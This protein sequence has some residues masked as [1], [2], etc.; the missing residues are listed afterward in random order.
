M[1]QHHLRRSLAGFARLDVFFV[2]RRRRRARG[3][4]PEPAAARNKLHRGD[5]TLR[6]SSDGLA[7]LPAHAA[8]HRGAEI[9]DGHRLVILHRRLLGEVLHVLLERLEFLLRERFADERVLRASRRRA[10]ARTRVAVFRTHLR[11]AVL[12]VPR[13]RGLALSPDAFSGLEALVV[14][15]DLLF[16]LEERRCL[17]PPPRAHLERVVLH[18]DALR[19]GRGFLVLQLEPRSG[20]PGE[21]LPLGRVAVL[22]VIVVL[23]T[24]VHPDDDALFLLGEAEPDIFSF[25]PTHLPSSRRLTPPAQRRP[26][27]PRLCLS[28]RALGLLAITRDHEL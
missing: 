21:V 23:A 22:A 16:R 5:Q 7:L 24:R 27:P 28:A 8:E 19:G 20:H 1:R 26:A 17:P 11:Q 14:L 2:V 15:H 13:L 25:P 9:L 3:A 12:H 10:V 18:R 6:V 4:E